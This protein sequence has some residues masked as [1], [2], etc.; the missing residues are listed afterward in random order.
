MI[1]PASSPDLLIATT[2]PGKFGE[3]AALLAG[4]PVRLHALAEFDSAPRVA[5]DG[6]SYRENALHKALTLARWS[7]YAALADDSGLEVDA[8]QGAPGVHSARYAGDQQD[9]D[10]NIRKL[11]EA[12]A[13]VPD[14]RRA[15]RFRCVIV[16]ARPDGATLV[17]EGTC[18][19]RITRVPRGRHGFG[20]D[21]VFLHPP[22]GHTF[23]ELSAA[24]KNHISHRARACR[25]LRPQLAGFLADS[26]GPS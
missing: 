8:L 23:A 25:Q 10:A 21:P 12:L 1:R 4:V 20:Y 11:L 15:A 13:D 6:A 7:R 5:E 17:T 2:N 3:F 14:A 22:S 18:E 9:S 16:V 24:V 26:G 19:G